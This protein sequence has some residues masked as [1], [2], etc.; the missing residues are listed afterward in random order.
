[1]SAKIHPRIGAAHVR[2]DLVNAAAHDML[3]DVLEK[4]AGRPSSTVLRM[5]PDPAERSHQSQKIV[6]AKTLP[7]FQV[8]LGGMQVAAEEFTANSAGHASFPPLR[9]AW[10]NLLPPSTQGIHHHRFPPFR[11]TT[12]LSV[13]G[14][15]IS[16]D[17]VLF[18]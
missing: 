16:P 11:C 12:H 7:A 14:L 5:D 17:K 3:V 10:M 4:R 18:G 15:L 1:V 13:E 8:G 9:V 2:F 6:S